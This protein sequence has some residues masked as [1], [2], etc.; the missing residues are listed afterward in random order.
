[1]QR[2]LKSPEERWWLR[3]K[4]DTMDVDRGLDH[5]NVYPVF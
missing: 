3:E 2:Q 4:Y 1:M 5:R